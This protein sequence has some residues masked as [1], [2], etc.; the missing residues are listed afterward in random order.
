MVYCKGVTRRP[1]SLSTIQ[2]CHGL[3]DQLC[4]F[5]GHAVG[6]LSVD[7]AP[8][9]L[10]LLLVEVRVERVLL[11]AAVV[12]DLGELCLA[13]DAVDQLEDLLAEWRQLRGKAARVPFFLSWW[14][15]SVTL[16]F[17]ST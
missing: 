17:L 13:E 3:L 5:E 8:Q 1:G 12:A 11:G 4:F 9:C 7:A 2:R 14:Y 16:R 6:R 15:F 10:E